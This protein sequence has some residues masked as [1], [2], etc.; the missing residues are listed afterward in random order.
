MYK[1][2]G[3]DQKEYGPVSADLIRQW[4]VE[5]RLNRETRVCVEGEIEWKQLS[6]LPEFAMALPPAPAPL[7]PA[8][9]L[10]V[11]VFG[12]LNIVFGALG[13]LCTPI[14]FWAGAA[15]EE[16]Y[17]H[18]AFMMQWLRVSPFVYLIGSMILLASGIGL[19]LRRSWARKLAVGFA[20]FSLLFT[21]FELVVTIATLLSS[22]MADEFAR[23]GGI[24]GSVVASGVSLLYDGLLIFFLTRP[25]VKRALGE[26]AG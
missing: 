25:T 23:I 24:V 8:L 5:G 16:I 21:S 26:E 22:P 9:P 11:K 1:I 19:C 15:S 17:G 4:I 3:A 10:A 13:L 12:V 7:P 2:I 20:L 14:L 18:S 6:E